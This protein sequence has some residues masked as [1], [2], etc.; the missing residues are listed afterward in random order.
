MLTVAIVPRSCG[1]I[2]VSHMSCHFV[3]WK[4]LLCGGIYSSNY[5]NSPVSLAYTLTHTRRVTTV[6]IRAHQKP[7]SIS[8]P[9]FSCSL[10][11]LKCCNLLSRAMLSDKA[12]NGLCIITPV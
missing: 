11:V 4:K 10:P 6:K 9:S 8:V 7:Y 3:C 2:S 5:L 1:L 12:V